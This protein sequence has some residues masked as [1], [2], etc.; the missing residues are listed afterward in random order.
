M[1]SK[2][3]AMV[4]LKKNSGQGGMNVENALQQ[5]KVSANGRFIVK[6]DNSPFYWLG[7]TAWELFARLDKEEADYYLR[8]RAEQGF[9][10][11]QAV[12]LAEL[13]QSDPTGNIYGRHPLLLGDNGHPDPELPDVSGDYSYWAHVDYIIDQANALSMYVALLPTWG[14]RFHKWPF[15]DGAEIFTVENA[16]TYG[17]WIGERYKSVP[18][19]VWVLGGDRPLHT[20]RHFEI[21]ASMARGIKEGDGGAHLITF[22]PTG[23]DS[24]SR[25]LHEEP[26]LDFNMVQSGHLDTKLTNYQ[27]VLAD[28]ERLPVK[29]VLDAEPC[30]E[31]LPIGFKPENGYFDAVDVRKAAY[32]AMLSGAFGHTYGHHSVWSMCDG[33]YA[34]VKFNEPGTFFIMSWKEALHRPGAEQMRHVAALFQS[35]NLLD[36]V[37]DQ[38]LI[39][40]NLE[41]I[42]YRVAARG[43]DY[44][45][46]YCPNGL[47][48]N[49]VMGKIEGQSAEASWFNPRD[50]SYVVAGRCP[51]EGIRRFTAPASGRDNDWVLCLDS[52]GTA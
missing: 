31:D 52:G 20:R 24:S 16:F 49:V 32:Y 23:P 8:T 42:S 29:P 44:A 3:S 13:D 12:A 28:Y 41:G 51:N 6:T 45:Y 25:Q 33:H 26:W 5:L 14:N 37:P 18:G 2:P 11:V 19:L 47:Y 7:D 38:S 36:L 35:R 48:V 39:S 43:R 21:I 27:L 34:T 9:T 17:K 40:G 46:I 10:I 1:A 15:D 4:R 30:Y 50:G 22:H